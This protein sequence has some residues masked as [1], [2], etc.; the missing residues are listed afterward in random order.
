MKMEFQGTRMQ[1]LREASWVF[2]V[3]ALLGFGGGGYLGGL[4]GI[5]AGLAI[6]VVPAAIQ[7]WWVR[8]YHLR[9]DKSGFRISNAISTSGLDR[10]SIDVVV[11]DSVRR[12]SRSLFVHARGTKTIIDV[13]VQRFGSQAPEAETL[14]CGLGRS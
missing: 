6:A 5:L 2:A 3:G 10:E 7:Y 9:V 8:R 1:A 14:L 12:T 13:K 11:G 4:L